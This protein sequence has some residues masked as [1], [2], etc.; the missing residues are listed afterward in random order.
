M[1]G[2]IE[3]MPSRGYKSITISQET[4]SGILEEIDKQHQNHTSIHHFLLEELQKIFPDNS[5]FKCL[6]SQDVRK[7]Q[8]ERGFYYCGQASHWIARDSR[9]ISQVN[10]VPYC[11]IHRR[12]VRLKSRRKTE[13][14]T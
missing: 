2:S 5:K 8:Y 7:G 12:R 11:K 3:K 4:Y 13:V 9:D 14:Y 6:N 10:G 1:R